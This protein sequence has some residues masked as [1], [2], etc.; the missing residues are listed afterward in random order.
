MSEETELTEMIELIKLVGCNFRIEMLKSIEH[1]I[2][3]IEEVIEDVLAIEMVIDC[4]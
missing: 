4:A 3:L 1:R 2:K